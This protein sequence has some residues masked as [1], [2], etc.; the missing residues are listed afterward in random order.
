MLTYAFLTSKRSYWF[1]IISFA[2]TWIAQY[3]LRGLLTPVGLDPF[4]LGYVMTI[5]YMVPIAL[6]FKE[7]IQAKFFV[8][9]MVTSL[10]QFNFLIF[11]FLELLIFKH[12]VG[13]LILIGQL[14]GLATI[15]LIRRDIRPHI[16]NILEIIDHQ[17]PILTLFPF[18]SFGLL[19][20]YGVKKRAY[21]LPEFIPL[22]LAAII[23]FASYYL[24]AIAVERSKRNQQLELISRTD[25]LTGHYNRRYMEQRLQVEYE[26]F[27]RTGTEFALIIADID[28]FKEINDRYGHAC[29]D[30]LLKLIAEDIR[31]SVRE[32]DAVARWGGDEFVIVLPA[33]DEKTAVGVAERIRE[34]VEK[35]RYIYENNALTV[36]MTL[37]V[38][39]AG[40]D[41]DTV[42]SMIN[43]ADINMYQ[44]KR[45]GR[46]RVICVD[47]SA[48]REAPG[49]F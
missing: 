23:I 4:L 40:N 7:T 24:M 2:G 29:G 15:P 37:G 32:Y 28:L 35:R 9:F 38:Y 18:L 36:T 8:L 14:L 42:G 12:I 27:Q 17:N 31:K 13:W 48:A 47:R 5:L 25:N 3:F 41:G 11:L 39:A 49:P 30:C 10:S 20:F 16:K 1:Q 19:A 33:T 44:G 43:K 46:N 45:A 6:V 22:V 21:L 34:T 26:R